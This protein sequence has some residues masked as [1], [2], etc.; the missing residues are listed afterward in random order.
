[1]PSQTTSFSRSITRLVAA[2]AVFGGTV[3]SAA[4]PDPALSGWLGK[5]MTISSTSFNDHVPLGSK[6]TFVSDAEEDIVRIC[7]RNVSTARGPWRN[8]MAPGC[9]VALTFTRGTRYCTNDEVK[10]GDAEVLSSCHRLRNQN[11]AMHPAAQKGAV[12]LHDVIVFLVEGEG[13]KKNISILVDSPARLIHRG[14]AV[15]GAN[16]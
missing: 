14:A 16:N 15:G 13:G 1:M 7:T 12:E 9:N 4:E 3:V 5:E 11:V 2:A 8:D 10:A 6:L